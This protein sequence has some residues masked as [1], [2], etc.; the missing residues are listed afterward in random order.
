MEGWNCPFSPSFLF[1]MGLTGIHIIAAI[2]NFDVTTLLCGIVYFL[3]IPSCFIFLQIYSVANL[4]DVSWGTRQAATK[5]DA[6]DTRNFWQRIIGDEI[7]DR[8]TLR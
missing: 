4:N 6:K 7:K 8:L 1:F 5:K 2:I 3:F